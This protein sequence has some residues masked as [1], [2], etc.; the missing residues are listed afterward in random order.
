MAKLRQQ[1]SY[2]IDLEALYAGDENEEHTR[3]EIPLAVLD[4]AA[5]FEKCAKEESE[6][7]YPLAI[8]LNGKTGKFYVD[9]SP[10]ILGD[11]S[12]TGCI[13]CIDYTVQVKRVTIEIGTVKDK[14]LK[15]IPYIVVWLRLVEE[16]AT[17]SKTFKVG[18]IVP[19][20][21]RDTLQGRY[22]ALSEFLRNLKHYVSTDNPLFGAMLVWEFKPVSKTS[23]SGSWCQL[24]ARLLE[25]N[26]STVTTEMRSVMK[27]NV[28]EFARNA[29]EYP[30]LAETPNAFFNVGLPKYSLIAA[31]QGTYV[32]IAEELFRLIRQKARTQ[33]ADEIDIVIS[34]MIT[35]VL[36]STDQKALQAST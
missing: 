28:E 2:T 21:V 26:N 3:K 25:V 10:I 22:G 36:E 7:I 5:K 19:L 30:E 1:P 27:T 6:K 8:A 4:Y 31:M 33:S 12:F 18:E 34:P 35:K 24:Q 11:V 14:I 29:A 32:V 20:L 13:T 9:C 23:E 15:N 17:E 16:V